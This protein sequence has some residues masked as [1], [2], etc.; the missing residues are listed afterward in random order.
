MLLFGTAKGHA[1]LKRLV[2][3][4]NSEGF[5]KV[6]TFSGAMKVK[7]GLYKEVFGFEPTCIYHKL[8]GEYLTRRD[9]NVVM[10]SG[11]VVKNNRKVM[12]RL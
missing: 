5:E 2:F 1:L 12:D 7:Y 6:L 3:K 8:F 10:L 4:N 9:F 11:A